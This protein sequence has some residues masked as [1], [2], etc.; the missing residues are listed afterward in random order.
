MTPDQLV[1]HIESLGGSLAVQGDRI[2][3]ELPVAAAPLLAELR[4]HRNAVFELLH[5]RFSVPVMPKGVRLIRWKP[6]TP[7]VFLARW[8][9]VIE[10]A[11]FIGI[12]LEALDAALAGKNWLGGNWTVRELVDRL[13]EVGIEVALEESN[14]SQ[15]AQE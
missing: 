2:C 13:E 6:K 5:T 14:D 1:Q 8:S 10:T 7:P 12:T 3:Y 15:T 4:A 11:K 9:V